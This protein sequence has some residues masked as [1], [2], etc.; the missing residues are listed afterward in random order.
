[1][2]RRKGERHRLP[3]LIL[4]FHAEIHSPFLLLSLGRSHDLPGDESLFRSI[5][6][7]LGI[8]LVPTL[9]AEKVASI[10][11][12]LLLKGFGGQFLNN[13]LSILQGVNQ[14]PLLRGNEARHG[15]LLALKKHLEDFSVSGIIVHPVDP[16]PGF[17][18]GSSF[19]CI[20]V[21]VQAGENTGLGFRLDLLRQASHAGVGVVKNVLLLL[22]IPD[23]VQLLNQRKLP[24]TF[25]GE[26]PSKDRL[27][28][29]GQRGPQKGED[30]LRPASVT[31]KGRDHA[32]AGQPGQELFK[33]LFAHVH[34]HK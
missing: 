12:H 17:L 16:K 24:L 10:F 22:V 7:E 20:R 2:V 34:A 23:Q 14:V 3:L 21:L 1:M 27:H 6:D 33:I 28:R 29:C 18:R 30:I 19:D 31:G 26:A 15:E 8:R 9:L 4:N 25:P 32:V 11:V 5:L 13:C